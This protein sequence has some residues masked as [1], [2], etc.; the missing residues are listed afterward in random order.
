MV[1]KPLPV[2]HLM[3]SILGVAMKLLGK[4]MQGGGPPRVEPRYFTRV[5]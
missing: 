4:R 2:L 3:F 1:H 5:A